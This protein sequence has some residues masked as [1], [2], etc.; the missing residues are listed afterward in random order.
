VKTGRG[1]FD[2]TL[3]HIWLM[4]RSVRSSTTGFSYIIIFGIGASVF[5]GGRS[6]DQSHGPDWWLFAVPQTTCESMQSISLPGNCASIKVSTLI[7]NHA[8]GLLV[9]SSSIA[10]GLQL[11]C[12]PQGGALLDAANRSWYQSLNPGTSSTATRI[13]THDLIFTN[14]SATDVTPFLTTPYAGGSTVHCV[15]S[16]PDARGWWAAA[17]Q[18]LVIN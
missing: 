17:Y 12:R 13:F 9:S 2:L 18:T 10:A 14:G 16:A 3:D 8:T 5:C 4:I 6:S 7:Y 1:Y 15:S 11:E